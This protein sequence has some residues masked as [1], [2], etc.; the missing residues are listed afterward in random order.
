MDGRETPAIKGMI[1]TSGEGLHNETY[2]WPEFSKRHGWSIELEISKLKDEGV[3]HQLNY[4]IAYATWMEIRKARGIIIQSLLNKNELKEE[5]INEV[6][7]TKLSQEETDRLVNLTTLAVMN[8]GDLFWKK[9]LKE[10]DPQVLLQ[11][12]ILEVMRDY[13]NQIKDPDSYSRWGNAQVFDTFNDM[14]ISFYKNGVSKSD[15]L[16]EHFRWMGPHPQLDGVSLQ[17]IREKIGADP[18]IMVVL[19]AASS[20]ALEA[21]I[22]ASYMNNILKIPTS[23][24][25]IFFSKGRSGKEEVVFNRTMPNRKCIVIPMDDQVVGRGYSI[26]M[27]VNGAR[28]KYGLGSLLFNRKAETNK[29]FIELS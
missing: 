7:P 4:R 2:K 19:A 13:T 29:G 25:P 16:G 1:N 8:N 12:Q 10:D 23:V 24:D 17:S 3:E 26:Q 14:L 28:A 9:D 20:G 5:N 15:N 22:F 18:K 11:A 21:G 27:A 6:V